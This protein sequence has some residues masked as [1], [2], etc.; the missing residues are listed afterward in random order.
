M[1]FISNDDLVK[2]GLAKKGRSNNFLASERLAELGIHMRPVKEALQDT[3][4]KYA[5]AK[6]I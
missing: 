2:Q 3:M 4:E 1:C 5:K 6:K